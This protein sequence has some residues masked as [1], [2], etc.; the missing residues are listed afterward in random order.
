MLLEDVKK[1]FG[2]SY[3]FHQV[4]GMHH[5]CFNNWDA[6]GYV[7]IL[8]QMKLEKITNGELKADL[9]HIRKES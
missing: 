8:T 2:T 6:R 9:E 3:R 4:T 7:P 1:Y 5:G